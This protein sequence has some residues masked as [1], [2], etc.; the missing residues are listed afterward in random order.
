MLDFDNIVSIDPF[1]LSKQRKRE[2]FSDVLAELTIHHYNNCPEYRRIL[3][4]LSFDP[5]GHVHVTAQS[6]A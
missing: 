6:A 3:D 1:S 5:T 2:L 4:V